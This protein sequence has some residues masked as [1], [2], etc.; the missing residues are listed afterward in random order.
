MS[1]ILETALLH[2]QVAEAKMRRG[3]VALERARLVEMNGR[4]VEA[5]ERAQRVRHVEMT[6]RAAVIDGKRAA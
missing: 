2:E 4:V 5:A 6:I 1:T 3:E